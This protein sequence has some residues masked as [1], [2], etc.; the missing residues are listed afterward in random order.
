MRPALLG[1][2][3]VL[4]AC[5]PRRILPNT[6]LL[7]RPDAKVGIVFTKQPEPAAF[8]DGI[9]G[10]L[11]V[12]INQLMDVRLRRRLN[13]VDLIG[14]T[15]LGDRFASELRNRRIAA[16]ILEQTLDLD[17]YPKSGS[18]D[19]DAFERDLGELK[20][21][22]GLDFL[23]ILGVAGWG[24]IR[25]YYGVI[26]LNDPKG[27]VNVMG[28]LVDLNSGRLLWQTKHPVG[29]S[30]VE[31]EGDWDQPPDYPNLLVAVDKAIAKGKNFL[32]REF[33]FNWPAP[34]AP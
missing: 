25:D 22:E 7:T 21:R 5:A 24:T 29:L 18:K 17:A 30:R 23:I 34:A 11:D 32:V 27:Y 31:V 28:R 12:A 3:A 26:P 2:L 8:K 16:R 20:A 19:A 15:S 4:A 14:F 1:A 13:Q 33:F 9:Q 10:I 6:A